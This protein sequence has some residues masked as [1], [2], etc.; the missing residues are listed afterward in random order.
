MKTLFAGACVRKECCIDCKKSLNVYTKVITYNIIQF[1][2]IV[3]NI[4]T[5][6]ALKTHWNDE[7]ESDELYGL[8]KI[9]APSTLTLN[10]IHHRKKKNSRKIIICECCWTSVSLWIIQN[11]EYPFFF[12]A[13]S[14]S[15]FNGI[16]TCFAFPCICISKSINY[17]EYLELHVFLLL[18]GISFWVCS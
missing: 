5:I 15:I 13:K 2:P 3:V 7:P 1:R 16:L 10:V 6:L 14:S 12:S 9:V 8:S 11:Y 17:T 18:A 4:S